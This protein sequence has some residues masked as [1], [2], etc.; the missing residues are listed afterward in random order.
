MYGYACYPVKFLVNFLVV[1]D[2]ILIQ[3]V[4]VLSGNVFILVEC[5]SAVCNFMTFFVK[6]SEL[7]L[8]GQNLCIRRYNHFTILG[9][10]VVAVIVVTVGTLC[11]VTTVDISYVTATKHVSESVLGTFFSSDLTAVDI[12]LS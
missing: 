2:K 6:K 12:N 9:E 10:Q 7:Y 1:V 11:A 3:T 5:L 8:I 4:Q